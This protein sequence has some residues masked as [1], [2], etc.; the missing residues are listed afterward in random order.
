ML[1]VAGRDQKSARPPAKNS[2]F[3]QKR[4]LRVSHESVVVVVIVI[5]IEPDFMYILFIRPVLTVPTRVGTV[6]VGK[7]CTYW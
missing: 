3:N 6:N 2:R 4:D 7:Y 1:R 5:E